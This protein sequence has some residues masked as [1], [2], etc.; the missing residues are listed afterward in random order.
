MDVPELLSYATKNAVLG[1]IQGPNK[2]TDM[3]MKRNK[4]SHN[5]NAVGLF[6]HGSKRVIN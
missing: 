4:N 2:A 3:F 6:Y 5:A 1:T